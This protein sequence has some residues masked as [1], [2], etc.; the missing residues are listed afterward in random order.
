MCWSC[1]ISKCWE[2]RGNKW[3]L[4]CII[5]LILW[6]PLNTNYS[7]RAWTNT[8]KHL[9]HQRIQKIRAGHATILMAL[10][11]RQRN[12]VMELHWPEKIQKSI[13]SRCQNGVATNSIDILQYPTILLTENMVTM[14]RL[15]LSR[16]QLC[17]KTHHSKFG[18]S[19][20]RRV[21]KSCD[22]KKCR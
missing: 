12:N 16:A 2:N 11:Q 7:R 21:R 5:N 15:W 22:W 9:A 19:P 13:W 8:V 1:K 14:S 17:E 3:K 4:G 6:N 20:P 10:Q 18:P